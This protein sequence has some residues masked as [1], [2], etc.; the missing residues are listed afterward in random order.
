MFTGD[1]SRFCLYRI[2][3]IKGKSYNNCY[4]LT[5]AHKYN[6]YTNIYKLYFTIHNFLVILYHEAPTI[7]Y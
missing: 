7:P 2:L 4:R 3:A 6:L 1:Y 5:K